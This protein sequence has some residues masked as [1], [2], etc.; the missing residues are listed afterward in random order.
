MIPFLKLRKTQEDDNELESPVDKW[1]LQ[2]S[3]LLHAHPLT[4]LSSLLYTVLET[5]LAFG[6]GR[7]VMKQV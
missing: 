5:V 6:T 7:E 3:A 4:L 1:L 2:F